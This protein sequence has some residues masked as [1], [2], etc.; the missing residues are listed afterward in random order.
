MNE[1]VQGLV[2]QVNN[3]REE[4]VQTLRNILNVVDD[5]VD[6]FGDTLNSTYYS[7]QNQIDALREQYGGV[8]YDECFPTRLPLTFVE[9]TID[10]VR[11]CINGTIQNTLNNIKKITHEI[12]TTLVT[13]N[14]IPE[15]IQGC[16]LRPSCLIGLKVRLMTKL[17]PAIAKIG[18]AVADTTLVLGTLHDRI[19]P[20][21]ALN[22]DY[23]DWV[24]NSVSNITSCV[25]NLRPRVN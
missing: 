21:V 2:K 4:V 1:I 19:I 7:V 14:E 17:T 8:L 16:N 25:Q 13:L 20:C 11:K 15:E 6:G 18:V 12:D 5:V 22:A 9:H 3:L 24:D 23:I 10:G